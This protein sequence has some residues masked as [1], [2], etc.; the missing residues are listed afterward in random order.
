[1]H[2]LFLNI[3]ASLINL[4]KVLCYQYDSRQGLRQKCHLS[5]SNCQKWRKPEICKLSV[6]ERQEETRSYSDFENDAGCAGTCRGITDG[7]M[8]RSLGAISL[9]GMALFL[10]WDNR[11]LW[12]FF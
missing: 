5:L 4:G 11:A 7:A 12:I 6:A 1:V 9:F 8:V 10:G 3:R 2:I